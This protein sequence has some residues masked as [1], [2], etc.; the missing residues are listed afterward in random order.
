[1]APERRTR[2][3]Q[4]AAN[5]AALRTAASE[6]MFEVGWE[7]TT[8]VAI[9]RRAGLTVGA[10]YARAES[11]ED[12]AID[13]WEH[14]VGP[15]FDDAVASVVNSARAGDPQGVRASLSHWDEHPMMSALVVELLVAAEFD[16]HLSEVIS[17]AARNTLAGYM[18]PSSNGEGVSRHA[19]AAGVLVVSFALGR[20]IAARCGVSLPPV[21]EHEA[22]VQAG[23]FASKPVKGKIPQG[24][25]LRWFRELDGLESTYRSVVLGALDVVG[26]VGYRN[27]TVTRI[28]RAAGVPRGG[29]LSHFSS[30]EDLLAYS[31]R[32]C[33]IPPREVWD[34][35]STIVEKHGPLTSRAMFLAQFLR[36][37]NRHAWGI[38]LELARISRVVPKL[39]EFIPAADVLSITHLGV[40]LSAIIVPAL[41]GLPYAGPFGA[42][43]AT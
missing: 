37:E 23:M 32:S 25:T 14:V 41:D 4:V 27:A 33:L 35:Y 24:P 43:T 34:Q 15:W 31:A 16:Q 8:F 30:K 28:A 29:L 9:A 2:A 6:I 10:L 21:S 17:A 36:P 39:S 1:M 5:D 11:V 7:S 22:A 3:E 26:R 38:N 42:G 18:Q 20:A 12:V 19:A 40:M 13:L